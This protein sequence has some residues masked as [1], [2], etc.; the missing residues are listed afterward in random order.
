M[1]H[2]ASI[3][4]RANQGSFFSALLPIFDQLTDG[5][6]AIPID[7]TEARHVLICLVMLSDQKPK[8]YHKLEQFVLKAVHFG[9][10][11][12]IKNM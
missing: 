8:D 5:L 12:L 2:E 7:P 4:H 10:N 1:V 11:E 3:T 9:G 6:S